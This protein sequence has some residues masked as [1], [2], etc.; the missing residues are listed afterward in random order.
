MDSAVDIH[1]PSYDPYPPGIPAA[2]LMDNSRGERTVIVSSSHALR[3][4]SPFPSGTAIF[5]GVEVAARIPRLIV[6]DVEQALP[7]TVRQRGSA[8]LAVMACRLA[9]GFSSCTA[10]GGNRGAP[11][12]GTM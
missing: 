5:Y 12:P 10:K 4:S 6:R 3:G 7:R 9:I 8:K 2:R 11:V 1:S